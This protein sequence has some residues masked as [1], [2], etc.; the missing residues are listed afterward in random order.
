MK[1]KGGLFAMA[2]K[3]KVPIVPVSISHAHA[4][5]PSNALFPVQAGRGKLHVHVHDAIDVE[6]QT[7]AQLSEAVREAFLSQLP[8]DQQ[9]LPSIMEMAE[10]VRSET[11]ELVPQ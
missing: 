1:F 5:M 3:A 2:I 7:E 10:V 6:G 8:Y 4:I 11:R 9:P